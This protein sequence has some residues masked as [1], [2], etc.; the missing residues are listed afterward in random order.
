[1]VEQTRPT[2]DE[3]F[4][5]ATATMTT[6]NRHLDP[7]RYHRSRRKE[8]K[9]IDAVI[10][11]AKEAG[12]LA[13][14][15]VTE[16]SGEFERLVELSDRYSGFVLP[17]L[18]VHPVQENPPQGQRAATLQDLQTALPLIEKYKEYL[19]AIGEVGL[20]FTPRIACTE[21]QKNEQRKVF[22]EQIEI[23]KQLDL[24]L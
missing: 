16:H 21:A 15:A 17:C 5:K 11:Q 14:V 7:P 24:P 22:I 18:G 4:N 12:L 13:L 20:D 23:A 8:E 2:D 19:L 9:D 6:R 1:M 10:E 3:V